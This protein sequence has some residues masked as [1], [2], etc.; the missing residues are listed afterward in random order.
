MP[1]SLNVSRVQ[2]WQYEYL[3]NHFACG[4]TVGSVGCDSNSVQTNVQP[5]EITLS[6]RLSKEE[7]QQTLDELHAL[8][9]ASKKLH[10][11]V[12]E[13]DFPVVDGWIKSA[14]DPFPSGGFSIAYNHE[15]GVTLT[16]Y[17]YTRELSVIPDDLS[18]DVVVEEFA[19]SNSGLNE[20][21][22]LGIYD[23]V[24]LTETGVIKLGES[25]TNSHWSSYIVKRDDTK[26]ATEVY[27]WT[28][29]NKFYKLRLSSSVDRSKSMKKAIR[30][31]LTALG[32]ALSP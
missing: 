29:K 5:D 16:L 27:L 25:E 30:D 2:A 24:E 12:L 17:Q 31:L 3:L 15:Q 11:P 14:P 20:A 7:R 32:E 26:S 10:P 8:Q 19:I 18:A 28:F 1:I 13:F 9:E 4:P 23:S 6:E 21:V 22:D